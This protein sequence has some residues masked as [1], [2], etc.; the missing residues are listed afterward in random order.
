[1]TKYLI[2]LLLSIKPLFS[3]SIDSS[4]ENYFFSFGSYMKSEVLKK[5]LGYQ[6]ECLGVYRLDG[7]E[8]SY[9]L[10][11]VNKQCTG[12]N[13]VPKEGAA[14]YGVIWKIH[15]KDFEILDK[16]ENAPTVYQRHKFKV[17]HPKNSQDTK[18]VNVYVATQQ[19]ISKTCFPRPLYV[20]IVTEGAS[21]NHLPQE[22]IDTYLKW[23]GPWGE[24]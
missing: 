1:M 21:E 17:I 14:V 7:Y 16:V 5:D 19:Y 8:F 18:W 15:S 6:P 13:I 24:N 12:G 23:S 20:K 9:N 11:V 22:Y 3:T 10:Y 4:P 2:I